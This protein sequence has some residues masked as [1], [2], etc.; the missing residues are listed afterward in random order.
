MMDGAWSR[1]LFAV[2]GDQGIWGRVWDSYGSR[3][4]LSSP[5]VAQVATARHEAAVPLAYEIVNTLRATWPSASA[6]KAS[7]TCSSG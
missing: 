4:G 5:A 6:A 1:A 2:A 7:L 3:N